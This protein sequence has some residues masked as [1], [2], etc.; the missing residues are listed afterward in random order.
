MNESIYR[1]PK[2]LRNIVDFE[3]NTGKDI[4]GEPSKKT[5][6]KAW[7]ERWK[8]CGDRDIF[9]NFYKENYDRTAYYLT[10][11]ELEKIRKS[12][13]GDMS[14]WDKFDKWLPGYEQREKERAER[15]RDYERKER[16]AS[17]K[18]RQRQN[19]EKRKKEQK[20]KELNDELDS[21]YSLMYRDFYSNPYIDKIQ[22][23]T[24]NGITV[25]HYTFED[26]RIVKI[27]GNKIIW[28]SS[29]YTV[30]LLYRNRFTQ[31]GNDMI[32]Q[33]RSRPRNS[34]SYQKSTQ[35]KSTGHPKEPLYNTLKATIKQREDQLKKMSKNDP[36]RASLENEL[37][38]AQTKLK[39]MK[40][41]Y[42]FENL[43]YFKDFK[44]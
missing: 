30:G 41:K 22:T 34:G 1:S 4:K 24:I 20:Q 16:E 17:E 31:L 32:S 33:A 15:L 10:S 2:W 29:I 7:D 36:D 18:E 39:A 14:V 38:T 11:T 37:K 40:D 42:Q 21:L 5:I 9:G 12:L 8:E 23:P 3:V 27:E 43:K 25:F 35:K 44:I 6:L 26:G 13:R 28:G 19:D